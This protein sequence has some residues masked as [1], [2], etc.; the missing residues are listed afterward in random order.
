MDPKIIRG[1]SAVRGRRDCHP[2]IPRL[3]Q[4]GTSLEVLNVETLSGSPPFNVFVAPSPTFPV[5]AI[6]PR[7][8]IVEPSM[9]YRRVS[10]SLPSLIPPPG[11][12]LDIAGVGI[13]E[14]QPGPRYAGDMRDFLVRLRSLCMMNCEKSQSRNK[15]HFRLRE[16][17][18]V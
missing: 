6:Q 14:L 2:A 15:E 11:H 13:C 16:V 5:A 9:I 4:A 1:Q 17:S 12:R 3:I 7:D 10:V 18:D 8:I